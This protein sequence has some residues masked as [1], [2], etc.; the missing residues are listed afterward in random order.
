[1]DIYMQATCALPLYLIQL[2]LQRE[3]TLYTRLLCNQNPGMQAQAQARAHLHR[4]LA[5][6]E[7]ERQHAHAISMR[8]CMAVLHQ[9]RVMERP[10][11]LPR[12]SYPSSCGCFGSGHATGRGSTAASHQRPPAA[13]LLLH[14]L[15]SC[16]AG[17][18]LLANLLCYSSF[19]NL[20]P[21]NNQFT[22]LP[23]PWQRKG[24]A[25]ND[26][27]S[28]QRL[29]TAPSRHRRM[30]GSATTINRRCCC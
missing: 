18:L 10:N 1:M 24:A 26:K 16:T 8:T 17:Q 30:R 29:L 27:I 14:A 3:R 20:L 5:A 2:T 15:R 25:G 6:I 21:L 28:M 11:T 12:L 9:N 13:G 23:C 19:C 22:C 4:S 7:P